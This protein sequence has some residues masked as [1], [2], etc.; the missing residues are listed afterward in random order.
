MDL[1][2]RKKIAKTMKGHSNFEGHRHTHATKLQIGISQEGH[3]NVKDHKWVVNKETGKTNRVKGAL[4]KGTKWGR[5]RRST[6]EA[7]WDNP[8]PNKNSDKLSPAMK[9]RAKARA[10]AAGRPYPNMID[11]MWAAKNEETMLDKLIKMV[12][13]AR[14]KAT[15]CGRC[16]TTHVPPG[17]GGKCPALSE[18]K[19]EKDDVPFDGP[20]TKRTPDNIKDKSGATHTPMSR[21]RHLARM[22]LK[23][24]AQRQLGESVKTTHEDPLVTVHDKDGL[25]THANLSTANK[26]FNTK[27]KHADVHAGP[28][29]TK[30]GWETKKDLTF[31]ISKHHAK[32]VEEEVVNEVSKA[33]LG[34][35][36]EKAHQSIVD[37]STASSFKSGA[38]GDKYNK[39]DETP[40][41]AKRLAGI[42]RAI[43]KIQK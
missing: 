26:I 7:V 31:A 35:Y 27:V 23:S 15:Y 5:S 14:A 41:E 10:K 42:K 20:Y 2:T 25:H 33:T 30:D 28:V 43:K 4:P 22:A 16:G 38:A 36:I 34:S 11:N 39:A 13:E 24:K 17:K 21:A 8:S 40:S 1:E 29:K 12:N 32:S 19:A 18:G 9:A 6:N 3:R 37:T